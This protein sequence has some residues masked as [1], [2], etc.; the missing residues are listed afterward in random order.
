MAS[1][2][3]GLPTILKSEDQGPSW[4]ASAGRSWTPAATVSTKTETSTQAVPTHASQLRRPRVRT[5]AKMKPMMAATATKMA[6]QAPWLDNAF[7]PMDTPSMPESS[8]QQ[9]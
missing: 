8:A 4:G 7:N 1:S 9:S 6:V 5:L 2:N 3:V